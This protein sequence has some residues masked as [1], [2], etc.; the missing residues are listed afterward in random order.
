MSGKL[1][2]PELRQLAAVHAERP[3]WAARDTVRVL[4][5]DVSVS[6]I[7]NAD[8]D[9]LKQQ[10]R[11]MQTG[12]D[13]HMLRR[14]AWLCLEPTARPLVDYITAGRHGP[15]AEV[16]VADEHAGLSAVFDEGEIRALQTRAGFVVVRHIDI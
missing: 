11:L 5:K 13:P 14:V 4:A 8:L 7:S 16:A 9:W 3:D 10:Y 2:P 6:A 1:T 15:G 12:F